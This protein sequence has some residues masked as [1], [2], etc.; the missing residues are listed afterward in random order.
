[1]DSSTQHMATSATKWERRNERTWT[2]G[3]SLGS[4]TAFALGAFA[5]TITTLSCALV[6]WR[7]LTMA[8]AFIGN[9]F[10]IAGIG[11]VLSAQWELVRGNSY[12]YTV[13]SAY[14]MFYGGFGAILTPLFGVSST[15]G[16]DKTG[17]NN[18]L[19]FFCVLW[20]VFNTFFLLGSL[21][22]NGVTVATY[23]A[24]EI[25]LCLLGAS[26]FAAADGRADTAAAVKKAAGS[27]AFVA[28]ML[29]YYSMG[30]A[31]CRDQGL[32]SFLFPMGDISARRSG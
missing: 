26:Y 15:F 10:F 30:N 17:Y 31:I 23:T 24:L 1:M 3:R 12:N 5:T 14:G 8:N 27:F 22:T 25:Y 19:G 18:A 20:T 4:P 11:M 28:G 21:T 6:E 29:G 13:F 7:G 16:D 2:N 32:P 9:F